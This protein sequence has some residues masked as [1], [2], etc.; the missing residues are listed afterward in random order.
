YYRTLLTYG[1]GESVLLHRLKE[2]EE[3]L[4][5]DVK[6]AYLPSNSQVRLR[7]LGSNKCREVV[8][9]KINQYIEELTSLLQDVAVGIEE[10]TNLV[11]QI[12]SK[13]NKT[14]S[15]LSIAESVT[16]GS[17]S[18]SITKESGVSS[19]YAGSVITYATESKANILGVDPNLIEKHSV[20][21]AEVAKAM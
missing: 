21:S 2:W 1:L 19:F 4:P 3:A 12:M 13:L 16:G 9:Q 8:E 20:V 18:Q 14:N 15:T 10:E 17:L 5:S 7:L 11:R 6:L